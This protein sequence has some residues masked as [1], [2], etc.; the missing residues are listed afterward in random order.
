MTRKLASTY[1]WQDTLGEQRA[2][3]SSIAFC[4]PVVSSAPSS[5]FTPNTE[6]SSAAVTMQDASSV[7]LPLFTPGSGW[8]A[9]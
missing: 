8:P 1:I 7:V 4:N 5:A 3:T 9:W 6:S 2:L